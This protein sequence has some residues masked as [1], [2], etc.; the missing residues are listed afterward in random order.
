[1]SVS[2]PH[3][4]NFADIRLGWLH[5]CLLNGIRERRATGL[6]SDK[7][8]GTYGVYQGRDADGE[9]WVGCGFCCGCVLGVGGNTSPLDFGEDVGEDEGQ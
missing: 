9:E 2:I 7:R 1:M 3:G 6:L 8:S 5:T 4:L